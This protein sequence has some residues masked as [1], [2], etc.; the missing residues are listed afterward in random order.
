MVPRLLK[1]AGKERIIVDPQKFVIGTQSFAVQLSPECSGY[2]GI[3]LVCAVV[4]VYF[5]FYRSEIR[6]PQAFLLLPLAVTAIWMLNALRIA[7]L[8]L[9]GNS[10]SEVAVKG[11]HSVAGWLF[12]NFVVCGLIWTSSRYGFFARE[13]SRI[14]NT[15]ARRRHI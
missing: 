1:A 11:F 9:I 2:E 3:G 8:I 6:F 14:S 13:R 12:F 4:G 7:A 15:P 5:W 10:N